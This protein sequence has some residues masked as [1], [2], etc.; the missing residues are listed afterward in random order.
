MRHAS[1][2]IFLNFLNIIRCRKPTQIKFDNILLDCM[3]L[4]DEILSN[5]NATTTI[6]CINQINV[7]NY[8]NLILEKLFSSN[9]V[10]DVALDTNVFEFEHMQ[11]WIKNSHF[12]PLR[13]IAVEAL[14]LI[15]KNIDMSKGRIN[16]AFAI[17]TFV[18][19][20]ENTIISSI[21]IEI[22]NIEFQLTLNNVIT[23]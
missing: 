3:I 7:D 16:G 8:N 10:F 9:E 22:I 21:T 6:L 4:E 1:D 23:K 18:K 20:N 15:T 2:P 19:F 12:D 13:K 5:I 11:Q 14:V 17:I